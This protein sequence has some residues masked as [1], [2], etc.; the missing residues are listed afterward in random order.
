MDILAEATV[1]APSRWVKTW[2]VEFPTTAPAANLTSDPEVAFRDPRVLFRDHEYD[3]VPEH[4]SG[5]QLG[6]AWNVALP[7]TGTAAKAGLIP[8]D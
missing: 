6:V 3:S 4:G 1:W 8:T 2:S 5:E 7:P